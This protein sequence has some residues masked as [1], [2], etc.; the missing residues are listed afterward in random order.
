MKYHIFMKFY[1]FFAYNRSK[2]REKNEKEIDK[3]ARGVLGN[4]SR[5]PKLPVKTHGLIIF[6][7]L[8]KIIIK[9]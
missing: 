8:I 9:K 6:L 5:I 1:E 7:K 4:F 2:S 3:K